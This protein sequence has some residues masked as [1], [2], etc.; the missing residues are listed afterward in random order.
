MKH[1][2][3]RT[4]KT[5]LRQYLI[6]IGLLMMAWSC[7]A[8]EGEQLHQKSCVSCHNGM[9]PAGKGELIYS[10]DF[11]KIKQLA[12]LRQRV[13]TCASRVNAGWFEE[14]IDSVARWL[15]QSFYQF[16]SSK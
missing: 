2:M 7:H 1:V 9:F 6:A 15:N 8:T 12:H 4:Y 3:L 5:A 14:E 13:E 11:R 16:Q 10:A